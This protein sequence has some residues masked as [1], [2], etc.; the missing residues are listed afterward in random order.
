MLGRIFLVTGSAI[1]AALLLTACGGDGPDPV[2]ESLGET[3]A[4]PGATPDPGLAVFTGP[5]G[6]TTCHTIRGV[7]SGTLAPELTNVAAVAGSR[8]PGLSAEGYVRRSIED[9]TSFVVP[10][11]PA[12]MPELRPQLTDQQFED[13]V[14]FLLSPHEG[15]GAEAQAP[16]DPPE[17]YAAL[18]VG[19]RIEAVLDGLENP[20]SLAATPDGRLLITE[21]QAGRVRVVRDGELQPQPFFEAAVYLPSEPLWLHEL[22][23]VG[24]A[25]DPEFETNRFVYVYYH[26]AEGGERRSVLVRLRD[27]DGLGTDPTTI[28]EVRAAP[29]CC[30]I[31]GNVAF[32]D[33]GSLFVT[34]G[35]HQRAEDAQRLDSLLGKVLRIDRDG[36]PMPDNPFV[37]R[38][39]ADPRIFSYGLRNPFDIA[40]DPETGRVFVGENGVTM[41]DSILQ[42]L[43]GVNYGWPEPPQ[44]GQ[45]LPPVILYLEPHGMAGVEFY[46]D[47]R[48]AEFK[49]HLFF[50]QFVRGG[51]LHWSQLGA[52]GLD[53]PKRDRILAPGC[54]TGVATG[55]EGFLYFLD[56]G[57]GTLFRI[58]N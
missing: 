28:L 56:Y 30:H 52:E 46:S 43:P 18:P 31:A 16:R 55:P 11:Y 15:L 42:V 29:E 53:T 32:G 40:S 50:C 45:Y 12:L 25:V 39:G 47:D 49:G 38:E 51:A 6:C 41:F 5:V 20:S 35:D 21:Q 27:V 37:G 14:R 48:L 54:T 2:V 17:Y 44:D 24:V 9:P 57:S 36:N 3:A 26:T 10:G 58:A 22:G 19:Y 13:L 8:I 4:T 33:D 34:V 7:S 1:L 23:M